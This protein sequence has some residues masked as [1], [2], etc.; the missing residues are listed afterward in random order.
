VK[1]RS[2][3]YR[4]LALLPILATAAVTLSACES[5]AGYAAVVNGSKI[6]ESTLNSYLTPK[7]QAVTS[8]DGTKTPPRQFV[9]TIITRNRVI[10]RLLE[11][12]GGAPTSKQLA[13]AK[14]SA[15][16]ISD[17]ALQTEILKSGL[18][19]KFTDQYVLQLELIQIAGTRFTAAAQLTAALAKAHVN[20][21]VSP[22]Y[23]V[24]DSATLSV[25]G[26]GKKNLPD[27]LTL[28]TAL[29]GDA[30][31]AAAQ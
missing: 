9:M 10:E 26:L 15:L 21:S 11:V 22:R 8:S 18:T 3:R 20:V 13:E 24:W 17:D 14:A 6:S 12:S 27:M 2:V 31:A 25:T 29:P 5:K 16:T 28:N 30:P 23:G 7:A 4:A 19:S 1:V